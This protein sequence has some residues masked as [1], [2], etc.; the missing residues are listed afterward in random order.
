VRARGDMGRMDVVE[1]MGHALGHRL[2]SAAG[3]KAEMHA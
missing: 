2:H 1:V 3:G